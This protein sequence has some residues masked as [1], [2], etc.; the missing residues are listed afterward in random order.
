MRRHLLVVLGVVAV[1]VVL[2][3]AGVVTAQEQVDPVTVDLVAP[4]DGA[5]ATGTIPV[6][7]TTTGAVTQVR[8]S[9][10]ADGGATWLPIG[11]DADGADGWA[12]AWDTTGG[13][14]GAL[15]VK[16]QVGAVA[17]DAHTLVIDNTGPDLG[18]GLS[19]TRFSPNNDGTADRVQITTTA[20]E[21]VTL[22]LTVQR[23]GT[24]LRTLAAGVALGPG[25]RT[26]DWQGRRD[27]GRFVGDHA[28]TVQ[29]EGIDSSG[30][31]AVERATVTAD[32][33][34]PRFSW[35]SVRPEPLST[36]GPLTLRF[37]VLGE[38]EPVTLRFAAQDR[39]GIAARIDGVVRLPGERRLRW[40]PAYR[41]G[42]SLY[43]G[44][45]LLGGTGRDDVG[46]LRHLPLRRHRVHRPV[47][48]QAL[49]ALPG[50]GRRVAITIDDCNDGAAWSAMLRTL[51][52]RNVR[53]TFFCIGGNVTRFPDQA[54][55]TVADGHT[56]GSHTPDHVR[57]T[58]VAGDAVAERLRRDQSM[59]WSLARTTPSPF[60]RP[61]YGERSSTAEAAAGGV[62]I[63][64]TVLWSIDPQDWE[65]PGSSAIA[66]HVLDRARP[67]SIILLHVLSDTAA[68]L[69]RIITG[70]RARGLQPVGLDELVHAAG[71]DRR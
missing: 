56:I 27:D 13:P 54:R 68:A 16:A 18:L 57:V 38:V 3:G 34:P 15:L 64:W 17:A 41:N 14:D 69:D 55:R 2:S 45:Y 30:T 29:A 39:N 43:P 49:K 59:W 19:R 42:T 50:A 53:A 51:R 71:L 26:F 37:R 23:R 24:V 8:F 65:R 44:L 20:T 21:P 4:L 1:G 47:V 40:R 22:T 32:T 31:T 12:L 60:W 25:T 11:V 66:T 67:G 62:G 7:A 70:L 63:R 33:T 35:L 58:Q 61:P 10:S 5:T 9:W 36:T 48:N 28:L 52:A 46:N 6:G